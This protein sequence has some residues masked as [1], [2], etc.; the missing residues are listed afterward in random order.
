MTRA[1][2]SGSASK[3]ALSNA[4]HRCAS[5]CGGVVRAGEEDCPGIPNEM[6]NPRTRAPEPDDWISRD[7]CTPVFSRAQRWTL[8]PLR[9]WMAGNAVR[10][11]TVLEAEEDRRT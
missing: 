11:V 10:N 6:R 4:A 3:S 8:T 5:V 1:G 9:S 7:R 2:A